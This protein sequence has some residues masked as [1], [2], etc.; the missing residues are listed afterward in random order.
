MSKPRAITAVDATK[1]T[2]V[3][4]HTFVRLRGE[5]SGDVTAYYARTT[6]AR[7]TLRWGPLMM[8]FYSAE[9]AQG[10]LEGF[11]AARNTLIDVPPTAAPS[12]EAYDQP[13]IAVDWTRR[14]SYAAMPRTST[15]QAQRTAKWTDLYMGPVTF[16]ILDRAA[17]RSAIEVL[18]L[19]HTTAVAV[20]LDGPDF[21]N[22]PTYDD[23]RPQQ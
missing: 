6:D 12:G 19:A 15:N 17:F 9:A 7:V 21:V 18:R 2:G 8:T 23:Y 16:Q 20:C 1:T 22:D 10:V 13:A 11:A 5:Q 14:P 4:T 3:V